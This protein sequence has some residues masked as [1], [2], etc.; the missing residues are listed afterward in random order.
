MQMLLDFHLPG[1]L[2]SL[3]RLVQHDVRFHSKLADELA[4]VVMSLVQRALCG[5]MSS[6]REGLAVLRPL[7]SPDNIS[8]I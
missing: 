7:V 1:F 3:V 5:C 2:V 6:E 8:V 4:M